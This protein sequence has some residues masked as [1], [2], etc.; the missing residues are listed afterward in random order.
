MGN[1]W[2]N[3]AKPW[4]NYGKLIGKSLEEYGR[5]MGSLEVYDAPKW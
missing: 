2:E 4:K 5:I 1:L 3:H